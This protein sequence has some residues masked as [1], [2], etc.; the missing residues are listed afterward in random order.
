MAVPCKRTENGD[1]NVELADVEVR[2]GGTAGKAEKTEEEEEGLT[3]MHALR[4]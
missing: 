3:R 1:D 4:G 2:H